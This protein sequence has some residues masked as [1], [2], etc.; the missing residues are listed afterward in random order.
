MAKLTQLSTVSDEKRSRSSMAKEIMQ[1][2]FPGTFYHRM[3]S[4]SLS[5][6]VRMDGF[7]LLVGLGLLSLPVLAIAAL[8]RTGSLRRLLDDRY[9]DYEYTLSGLK[10]EI[11]TLRRS[12]AD[13]TENLAT[14]EVASA[15]TRSEAS[16][17][18]SVASPAR[19]PA[20]TPVFSS[21]YPVSKPIQPFYSPVS[22][23]PP[24]SRPQPISTVQAT[25]PLVEPV[26]IPK[27][28]TPALEL[29]PLSVPPPAFPKSEAPQVLAVPSVAPQPSVVHPP[30]QSVRL[31]SES[32]APRFANYEA[33]PPRP[34]VVDWL[35]TKLPLEEVLGMNLFAKIGIVL[36]VL[37]FALLGRVALVAMGPAGKV[38]LLYAAAATLLG[39]G[40]WLER[41]ER[42][43][44]IGRTGIG[45]GW[46][47]TFFTT[48]AMNHVQ[49]MLVMNS[50]TFNCVLLLG[51][52]IA[53]V[54]HTLRYQSQLVTGL[55]FLLAFSTV[56]LTQDTVY[57][58]SAGVILAI[59]IVAVALKMGWYE[60]EV[61]G[62]LAS[63]GN[64]F[65]WLYKLYP[66]G[67]AGHPFLQF[68]PSTVIL[69]LYWLIFRISYVAR[70]I[71]G[72]RDE[73]VSTIA[74]LANTV[75]L[76][77]V[78]KFQSTRPELA[79]Y[80]LLVLGALEFAFGQLPAT[81][82]RRPAFI[83]LTVIGTMLM[84]GSV[85][86][87]FSGNNIALLWM[88]AAET[89]IIAGIVQAEV[90]FRRIGL[91][92]GIVTGLL[93]GYEARHFFDLRQTSDAPLIA[94]GVQ[95]LTCGA[96]FYFNAHFIREKWRNLFLKLDG[97]L[98]ES[99]SYLGAAMAFLGVWAVFPGDW[100]AVGWAALMIGAA[101]GSRLL[102]NK[103]FLAQTWIFT[104]AVAVRAALVNCHTLDLYPHH[105]TA[106]LVTLPI[107]ALVF[108]L[109]AAVV[110]GEDELRSYLRSFAL[111]A[112]SSALVALAWFDAAP[113][114]VPCAW[115]GL[116]VA[117]CIASRFIKL[118]D[119][120]WQEHALAVLVTVR[121]LTSN[122]YAQTPA[123]RYAPIL[124]GAAAF[125]AM[126]RFCTLPDAPYR[127]VA[128]WAHT[129]AATALLATLAWHESPQPWLAVIW[130]LFALALAL[131]DRLF[132][133]EELPWQVHT[134][135]VLAIYQAATVNLYL[136]DKW[137]GID[138][139]LVTLSIVV[140]VLY[141]LAYY[142]RL[143]KAAR[144]QGLNHL[145]S[146]A[147]SAFA[148][149]MLWSELQPIA[150]AD[151][152]AI[153]GLL[154]FE[155]GDWLKQKQLRLQ[156]YVLLTVAFARIFFVNLTAASLPGELI[157][158]RIYTIVPIAIIN[159]FVWAQLQ[160]GKESNDFERWSIGNL[161]A[162]FGTGAITALLYFETSPEWIVLAWALLVVV[163]MLTVLMLDKELFLQ[164]ATLLVA[165]V[166]SRGIAHNIFG[167][168]YFIAGG[169]RGNVA[170]LSFV[171]A[172]LLGS[173]PIAFRL[174]ARYAGRPMQ[175]RL[176]RAL[177]L[178]RPE[179]WLFFAPVVLVTLMIAVKMNPGMVTLSW[180]VEA[181]LVIL[182]GLSVSERSYRITGLLLLLACVCK[183]VLRDAWRLT[184][185]DRY[186]TFIALGAALMLVST[187]YNRYR[188]SVRRLL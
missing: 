95:L 53:I 100:T 7:F 86:F 24:G 159:F 83:L 185:R 81:R 115:L 164:Q 19:E 139:R 78:M 35:R 70:G 105:V 138:L 150:V 170:V 73:R 106:R 3:Q 109:T 101:L 123:E 153:F 108:Y 63:F 10:G 20:Y 9:R 82:R 169:W 174:R 28:P 43:R 118:N 168:S 122:L 178:H 75:L 137:R 165:G 180:G 18:E 111:L 154:L 133:V 8:V 171:A 27:S 183:I 149:W 103:H 59:G 85:P 76:L 22:A 124:L 14:K 33:E 40:I 45:G 32:Q 69:V 179:Q 72:P 175:F 176:S 152:L 77:A 57:A 141:A 2:F 99:Q 16:S 1:E 186:I 148:A 58:L 182:L 120:C 25:A 125:Y 161:L 145:Y 64:H 117:L 132:D 80:A 90:V 94:T 26:A 96:L 173:L 104:A 49:A 74:A 97:R 110:G 5:G 155:C 66:T 68:W 11:A 29:P 177:A 65:Y 163:L 54:A 187:L 116:A 21:L 158:P 56:A 44:L 84:F 157:S 67:V 121:L 162:W 143:P 160:S 119:L 88:I 71:R 184:E 30:S 36:L 181:V 89:L 6:C 114:W 167:G 92:A 41:N 37:G 91:I 93:V 79:F 112:G 47:L 144:E 62:I 127:R 129:W 87:K 15:E 52:A 98:A 38:A 51:V 55:A 61:F 50:E 136:L 17:T 147:G 156:A 142:A 166:V 140:A 151:G 102:N 42:Y 48:Y 46:A 188:E 126:S 113:S 172:L 128:G 12:L 13:V 39:G 4:F 134:L 31:G 23:P 146:W 131:V 34:G 135:A 130:V 60:L 107:L